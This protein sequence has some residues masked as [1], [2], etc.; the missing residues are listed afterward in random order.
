MNEHVDRLLRPEEAAQE[1]Q[2]TAG[3]L[4][5]WRMQSVGPKFVRVGR[6]IRYRKS[7]IERWLQ[8]RTVATAEEPIGQRAS[9]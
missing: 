9:A 2:N 5:K 6:S 1:L 8:S 4:A 3:T 7:D